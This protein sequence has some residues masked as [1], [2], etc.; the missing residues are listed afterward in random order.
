MSSTKKVLKP[1]RI[2]SGALSGTQTSLE[3]DVRGLDTIFLNI[4]W[5]GGVVPSATITVEAVQQEAE[6]NGGV[7]VWMALDLAATPTI[8]GASGAHQIFIDSPFT[9]LR[10]TFVTASGAANVTCDILGKEG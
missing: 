9:K 7:P 8:S 10:V 6:A 1:Y 5:S 2:F 4:A 3:T